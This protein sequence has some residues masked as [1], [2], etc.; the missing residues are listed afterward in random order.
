MR[1]IEMCMRCPGLLPLQSNARCEELEAEVESRDVELAAS[2][3]KIAQ[4]DGL[5]HQIDSL[6]SKVGRAG[7]LVHQVESAGRELAKPA[8]MERL[9]REMCSPSVM[10]WWGARDGHYPLRSAPFLHHPVISIRGRPL[11]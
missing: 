2:A 4:M 10:L 9:H 8:M 3:A 1:R 7:R 5:R 11:R 6:N